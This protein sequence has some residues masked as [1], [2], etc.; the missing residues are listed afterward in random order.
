M[1]IGMMFP[2]ADAAANPTYA[3][4]CAQAAEAAG[5]HSLWAPE[6]V[7][8]FDDYE[9]RY[10]YTADG[11]VRMGREPGVLEPLNVLSF[12]AAATK[13]IRL[14]TGIAIVPQRNPVY[15]AKE[16]ATVD[17][18]SGGRVDFGIGIGWLKEEF[19]AVHVPWARRGARTMAYV[20]VMKT[21]WMDAVS[22]YEGEFYSL[23]PVRQYPKPVQKPHPPVIVGGDSDPALERAAQAD[24]W[25]GFDHDP[26]S[27]AERVRALTSLLAARGRKRSDVQV[28]VSPYIRA[29]DLDMVKEYREAG[30]DQLVLVMRGRD[31][32][33]MIASIN[34]TGERLVRPALSL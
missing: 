21:L 7:V 12:I 27:A 4:A 20:E 25:F 18:L 3:I 33:S 26:A 31:Q 13:T 6:H 34:D 9:S 24:G 11:R 5:F 15:M 23:P 22:R 30:V 2:L 29:V 32:E 19:G 28:I 14:G 8:A 10:P 17:V 16:V 1:H